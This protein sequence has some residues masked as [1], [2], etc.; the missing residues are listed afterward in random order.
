MK[1]DVFERKFCGSIMP[2]LEKDFTQS[3]RRKVPL[4]GNHSN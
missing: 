2:T 3:L 4:E 1:D